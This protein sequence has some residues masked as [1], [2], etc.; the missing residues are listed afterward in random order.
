VATPGGN[1]QV[2]SFNNGHP[3][4]TSPF[5][6]HP[7][8]SW[9]YASLL[10]EQLLQGVP[11]SSNTGSNGGVTSGPY[12]CSIFGVSSGG[13]MDYHKRVKMDLIH[14]DWFGLAPLAT[15]E[16]LSEV[17]SVSS[18]TSSLM[19]NIDRTLKD[20]FGHHRGCLPSLVG[21]RLVGSGEAISSSPLSVHGVHS[22]SVGVSH[23]SSKS[24]RF[25][26]TSK[27]LSGLVNPNTRAPMPGTDAVSTRLA[28]YSS[29]DE[30]LSFESVQQHISSDDCYSSPDTCNDSNSETFIS[31]KGIP[32]SSADSVTVNV[33]VY[34][35]ETPHSQVKAMCSPP[36][37]PLHSSSIRFLQPTPTANTSMV[38]ISSSP[39]QVT[40]LT[41]QNSM[42]D[43][44]AGELS[45]SIS[46][47]QDTMLVL[48]K[49]ATVDN[50][51]ADLGK[52][53]STSHQESRAILHL[54]QQSN[55]VPFVDDDSQK[56]TSEQPLRDIGN[57]MTLGSSEEDGQ[58]DTE[59]PN[60]N[61]MYFADSIN[62]LMPTS[63]STGT[64]S[65]RD[66]NSFY[67][68]RTGNNN[69]SDFQLPVSS[70]DSSVFKKQNGNVMS[71]PSILQHIKGPSATNVGTGLTASKRNNPG[72]EI[73]LPHVEM[74]ESLPLLSNIGDI[75]DRAAYAQKKYMYPVTSIGK[76]ESSV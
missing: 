63:S 42:S 19:L 37:Q 24:P 31:V 28:N 26:R 27:G 46:F 3:S 41:P 8:L 16:S 40:F 20:M 21:P 33:D 50:T 2:K 52:D 30:D 49:Q 6:L 34:Q 45:G 9:E 69:R 14:D 58:D 5:A 17:S 76:G 13:V 47:Q 62:V 65:A 10:E 73:S 66:D 64:C 53:V 36:S 51:R 75:H 57:N 22:S 54:G 60:R 67:T 74:M 61:V 55:Y 7:V 1:T 70:T 56:S 12:S 35:H 39:R 59:I 15:P 11:N 44:S 38:I 43:E 71:S 32:L 25:L 48:T 18:R 72:Y 4:I 29:G 23:M 68:S